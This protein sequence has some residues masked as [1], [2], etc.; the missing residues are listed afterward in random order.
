[1]VIYFGYHMVFRAVKCKYLAGQWIKHLL[2][3]RNLSLIHI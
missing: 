2:A 3:I 1:M